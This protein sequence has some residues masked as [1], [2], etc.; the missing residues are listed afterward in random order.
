MKTW[1]TSDFAN[2][3][4]SAV[5]SYAKPKLLHQ[6]GIQLY[7]NGFW[8]NGDKQNI[9]IWLD[10]ATWHDAKTGEGG[11]CKEFAKTAFNIS[12]SEFMER[13]GSS[14]SFSN[15][16]TLDIS[17]TFRNIP[18]QIK[19]DYQILIDDLFKE[20]CRKNNHDNDQATIWL[21]SKR[22]FINPRFYIGSGFISI[23]YEDIQIFDKSHQ[24]FVEKRLAISE[25][26]VVPLREIKSNKVK[27]LFFRSINE[28]N[29]EEKSRLLPNCGGW[30]DSDGA[31]RA[32]GFPNLI[33]EFGHLIICEGMADYF[34]V[35]CL[36]DC[37]EKILPI[38]ASNADGISKWSRW[39]S[40]KGYNGKVTIL[41]QL[42]TAENG[43]FSTK[44]IG[45]FKAIEALKYLNTHQIKAQIFDWPFFLK[46]TTTH[47]SL[48][49]DI[50]DILS[51]NAHFKEYNFDHLQETF[52]RTITKQ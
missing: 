6:K 45:V 30:H 39:L 38:G 14:N 17:N 41:Y 9:C 27:N 35:E 32:F 31:P 44:T 43:H 47:P 51:V 46:N 40:N 23:S 26:I 10:K 28:C 52:L 20:L 11:G 50:A 2:A 3:M 18:Q 12:L 49:K 19:T 15:I 33:E 4:K 42:D 8:R 29:K 21:K 37:N 34:A 1:S 5:K 13:F 48:I 25:Q 22:G 36:L 24:Y 7:F 16:S